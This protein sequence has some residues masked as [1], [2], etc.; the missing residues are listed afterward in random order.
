MARII[1]L[2]RDVAPVEAC[3]PKINEKLGEV[4]LFPGVRYDRWDRQAEPDN[5][6]SSTCQEN[7]KP[8]SRDWLDV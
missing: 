6:D 1:R 4:I 5:A 8:I 7:D 2:N 3:E